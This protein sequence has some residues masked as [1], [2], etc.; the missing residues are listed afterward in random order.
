MNDEELKFLD[1]LPKDKNGKIDF[2]AMT[3][4]QKSKYIKYLQDKAKKKQMIGQQIYGIKEIPKFN[5]KILLEG[6]DE[7]NESYRKIQEYKQATNG[8]S[9]VAEIIGALSPILFV[10]IL[11]SVISLLDKKETT[12]GKGNNTYASKN[13]LREQIKRLNNFRNFS[14]SDSINTKTERDL[15]FVGKVV[16]IADGD[17]FTILTESKSQVKIRLH[18]VDCPEY[19]QYYGKRA[20]QFVSD[21]VFGK[22]VEVLKTDDDKYGRVVAIVHV[23]GVCVNEELL[24]QG[25][26]WHYKQYDKS[27]RYAQLENK[28]RSEKRGL[29]AENNPVAPWDFRGGKGT[30]RTKPVQETSPTQ[31]NTEKTVLICNSRSSY[32]YHSYQCRGLS[33]CTSG[34]SKVTVKEA[35]NKGYQ[36]CKICCK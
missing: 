32:A 6:T 33:R 14:I 23:N 7:L 20:T 21:M 35:V 15:R 12:Y 13:T 30:Q 22:Q 9:F 28:A 36:P 24:K 19:Q 3:V 5:S 31:T 10:I 26:A 34:I 1:S 27:E 29:W 11:I 17:S 4:E 2:A 18:G 25:L 16:S 8:R